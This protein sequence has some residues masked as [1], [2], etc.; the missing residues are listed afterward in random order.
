MKKGEYIKYLVIGVIALCVCLIVRNQAALLGT[1]R[2]VISAASPLITG[3]I[4]AYV[5]NILLE[6]IEI[7][8]FPGT[9]S[10]LLIK[11]RRPVCILLS[12]LVLLL[13]LFLVS[14]LV[15]PELRSS[16]RLITAEIPALVEQVGK[17]AVDSQVSLPALEE[18]AAL[19]GLDLQEIIKKTLN[20]VAMGAGSLFNSIFSV[21]AG[22]FGAL[23]QFLI[24]GI[25][26]I[27]L[28]SGKE[29]LGEQAKRLAK[30]YLTPDFKDTLFYVCGVLNDTFKSFIIGQ[31]MEAVIIGVLCAAGM[32]VFRMPYAVMTGTVVG[33]TALIPV[34]GAY[35][36]AVVG[37]FMVFTVNPLQALFFILF[38]IVLQQLEGNLIYPKVVGSSIGLPGIWVLAAV[39][40]GGSLMGISGMLVGV[41][42]AA[43][44]YR[45]TGADVRERLKETN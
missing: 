17:L 33:V 43:A 37:A 31:C 38:L 26:A 34:V 27:Y 23:T 8:Y 35:I 12:L 39:T 41:P 4:I 28:L 9:K 3:C 16:I 20:M 30:A 22:V 11:S 10:G 7:L 32:F 36:G 24:G 13:I 1:V 21:L 2:G 15:V 40:V 42:L 19:Q 14:R 18:L 6:R 29:R 5:L 45:L 25:F 44:V